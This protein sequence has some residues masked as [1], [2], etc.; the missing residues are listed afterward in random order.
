MRARFRW[1]GLGSLLFAA[2]ASGVTID[3]TSVGDPGNAC[4]NQSQGCF[5]SVPYAYAIGTYE[6]T[7]AQ[8]AEFLNAKAASD[9]L[10]LYSTDMASGFGGITRSGSDGSYSYAPI[11]G[12]A[13]MPVSYVSFYDALRFANWLQ[14]GQGNSDTETGS[15]TLLGGTPAP[16]NGRLVTRNAD[17]SIVL[18][19]ENEWFKAAYYNRISATYSA[20]PTGGASAVCSAP[21]ASSG[22]ANCNNAVF[23]YTPRGSYPGSPSTY[24]TFDQGGNLWELNEE[25]VTGSRR[26][27]RGG[28]FDVSSAYMASSERLGFGPEASSAYV[29]FRL[30]YIPEPGTGLLVIAGVIG[31]AV[32]GRAR[33]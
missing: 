27:I 9:P 17:A 1:V 5:G 28:G 15:Y 12:R 25:I 24:G 6:V 23:D 8:Y 30:A 20:Y 11:S 22:R 31:F 13:N 32:R 18:P 4:S 21:S 10:R 14:N 29:G 19:T 2:S 26:V 3:W 33:A 7:N 16:S